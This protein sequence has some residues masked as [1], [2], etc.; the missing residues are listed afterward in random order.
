MKLVYTH[1][2]PLIVGNARGLLEAAGIQVALKNEFSVGGVGELSAFDVW[3]E[4]W[5]IR[6]RDYVL[7]VRIL[8]TSLSGGDAIDWRCR[9]CGEDNDASFETCW[10]CGKAS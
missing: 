9:N 5:V 2:N 7:A 1:E 10:H 6:D 8:E 3:P 4:L